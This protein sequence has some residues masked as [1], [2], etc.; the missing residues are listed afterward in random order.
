MMRASNKLKREIGKEQ[1]GFMEDTGN[2]NAIFMLKMISE[3]AIEMQKDVYA[4]FIDYTKAFDKVRHEDF[5]EILQ[6][7]DIDGKDIRV[8]RN[9]Y[10]ELTACMR[11]DGH[12]SDSTEIRR[13]VRQGCVFSPDLFN[14][15]SEK[16]IREIDSVEGFIIGGFNMNNIRLQMMQYCSLNLRKNCKNF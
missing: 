3:K 11:V 2:N 6:E 7:L 14:I 1:C 13:G 16:I 8:V 15:Y 12:F 9:L 4:C 5:M 10:W